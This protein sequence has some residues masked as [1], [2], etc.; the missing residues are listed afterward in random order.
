MRACRGGIRVYLHYAR[1]AY[2]V[3]EKELTEKCTG[4]ANGAGGGIRTHVPLRDGILSP[5]H[6][7][8]TRK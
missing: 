1:R 4:F 2:G 5:A 8:P 6:M 7:D 3:Q